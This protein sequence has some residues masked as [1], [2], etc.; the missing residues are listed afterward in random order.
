MLYNTLIQ[1]AKDLPE[2]IIAQTLIYMRFLRSQ[3][4]G[5]AS[6]QATA[7]KKRSITPLA[8]DFISIADDF[9]ETPDCFKEYV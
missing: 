7:S 6:S 3:A 9:D 1:E 2:E 4:S 5:N 8:D